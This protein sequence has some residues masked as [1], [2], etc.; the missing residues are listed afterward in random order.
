M[1][2]V[3]VFTGTDFRR[4]MFEY[5]SY[6]D[7]AR[8]QL[9]LGKDAPSGRPI[10]RFGRVIVEPI[11]GG[12]HHCCSRIQFPVATRVWISVRAGH[13]LGFDL[14]FVVTDEAGDFDQR[15]GRTN[16]TEIPAMD[17]RDGFPLRGILHIDASAYDILQARTERREAGRNF[18]EDVDGLPRGIA[19]ANDFV[20]AV[21]RGRTADENA[22]PDA[23]GATVAGERLPDAARVDV[24][25]VGT[26]GHRH[27]LVDA[28]QLRE[29]V[30]QVPGSREVGRLAILIAAIAADAP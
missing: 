18:V 30:A 14:D 10:E 28:W 24:H 29:M 21:G 4:I 15:I 17:A 5:T 20:P 25:P 22:R 3:I 8:T 2:H 16:V 11:V 13:G 7:E 27:G 23:L 6:Y 26:A 1:D 12:L 9:S 19:W